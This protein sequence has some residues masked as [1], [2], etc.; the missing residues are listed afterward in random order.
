MTNG[1]QVAV[2]HVLVQ[3]SKVNGLCM[4]RLTTMRPGLSN[5]KQPWAKLASRK[6]K[7]D[8]LT[9]FQGF[10]T[11]SKGQSQLPPDF[12]DLPKEAGALGGGCQT[13][14]GSISGRSARC[15]AL[16]QLFARRGRN[17]A[18]IPMVGVTLGGRPL[19]A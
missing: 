7:V 19:Q 17:E 10:F 6:T 18:E 8:P 13:T 3:D 4:S 15:G 9:C 11:G 16:V 14:R 12:A 2:C 5:F 1:V